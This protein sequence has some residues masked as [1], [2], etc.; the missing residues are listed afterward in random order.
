MRRAV[1]WLARAALLALIVISTV[2]GGWAVLRIAQDPLLRPLID[3]SLAGFAAGLEREMAREATPEAVAARL[4]AR[5]A[6][7]PRNW[8]AIEALEELAAARG[9]LLPPAL[10]AARNAAWEEDSGILTTA[11]GC[12]SCMVDAANCSLSQ[13]L[14][15]NAPVALTPIGDVIGLGRAGVAAASGDEVDQ[16]DLALSAIGLGATVAVVATGGTSY[17]LKAGTSILKLARKMSLLPPR[18]LGLITD[19][20]RRGIRWDALAR[21]DSVTDP[22]RLIVPEVVAP[23]AAVAAD[24]GRMGETLGTTRTLHL[25]RYVDGPDD[26]RH[27][28]N[29]AET[30]GPRTLGTLEVLGKSRFMRAALRWSDEAAALIFGLIGLLGA[31]VAM[32]AALAQGLAA[33]MLR[34]RLRRLARREPAPPAPAPALAPA[35][36]DLSHR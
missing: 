3:R 28:A 23:V 19:A 33:R 26:A 17:T 15:C 4:E 31:L 1:R 6:E 8:I 35:P 22:A 16:L 29:A 2:T 27:I 32:A 18:L 13:A 34:R 9:I 14:I 30:L 20:A 5:L 10:T 12:L 24:L 11:G 21:W 25:L 36:R 7:T